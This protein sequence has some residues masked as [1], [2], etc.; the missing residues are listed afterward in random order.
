MAS[1]E[2]WLSALDHPIVFS[3]AITLVVVA[4]CAIATWAFKAWG[5]PG[6]AALFQNP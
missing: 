4:W 1:R 3:I 2:E 5:L 6:P